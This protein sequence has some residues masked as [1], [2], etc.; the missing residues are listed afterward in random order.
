MKYKPNADWN[1][2]WGAAPANLI[3]RYIWGIRPVEPGYRRVMIKP[4]LGSLTHSEI[5]IPTPYGPI[6]AKYQATPGKTPEMSVKLPKGI[7]K[8]SD[9]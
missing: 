6:E 3:P 1:H 8:V 7:R 4:N 2:A 5:R 9:R